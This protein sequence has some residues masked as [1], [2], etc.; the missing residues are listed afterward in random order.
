MPRAA[1]NGVELY[2]EDTG[3]GYPVVFCHEFAGDYRSWEPQVRAFGHLYRCVTYSYR[4]F[5]PSEVPHNE[6]DYSQD[7]L[8]EDLR[9]LLRHLEVSEA[10]LVGLSMGGS[11]VLNFGLRYPE[12]CKAMVIVG[13][14]AG[15]TN[16]ERFERD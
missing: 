14:G 7:M 3:S 5:P 11:M 13:A 6:S 12:L 10:Y 1:V 15:T 9:A 2:Y 8:I 16:R 4:G